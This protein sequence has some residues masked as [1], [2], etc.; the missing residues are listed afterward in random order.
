MSIKMVNYILIPVLVAL[1]IG[2]TIF[3]DYRSNTENS[4]LWMNKMEE[5]FAKN[6]EKTFEDV[7]KKLQLASDYVLSKQEILEAFANKD[8]DMLIQYVMPIHEN[9]SKNYET[10]LIHFHTPDLKSFLR[11]NDLNKYGDSLDYRNDIKVVLQKKEPIFVSSPGKSGVG[12]RYVRPVYYN[13]EFVGTMEVGFLLSKETLKQMGEAIVYQFLDEYGKPAEIITKPDEVEDFLQKYNIENLKAGKESSFRDD[14]YFYINYP[15]KNVDGQTFATILQ[16][17]DA[18]NIFSMQKKGITSQIIVGLLVALITIAVVI[19]FSS[20]T[21]K[22]ISTLVIEIEKLQKERNLAKGISFKSGKDEISSV[23]Q[24]LS[25]LLANLR[26]IIKEFV[27]SS[28]DSNIRLGTLISKIDDSYFSLKAFKESFE[29]GV[30]MAQT[31]SSS[32]EETTATIE[33]ISATTSNISK[34][35]QSVATAVEKITNDVQLSNDSIVQMK[36]SVDET[37]QGSQEIVGFANQL[38]EKSERIGDILKTITDIAEQTNLLALNAAIEAARAGEAGRGFAV[39]ADEIRKLAESTRI[40]ATEIG[41]ILTELRDGVG[42]IS[43]RLESFD[44]KIRNIEYATKLVSQKLEDIQSEVT[45]LEKE[46]S[47]LAAV[48][49]EQSASIEEIT[50]AMA[51]L[52]KTAT[53][54]SEQM[55]MNK[56]GAEEMENSFKL[57]K[58]SSFEVSESFKKIASIISSEIT[59]FSESELK[60]LINSAIEAHEKWVKDV[61][62]A[63]NRMDEKL[64]VVLDGSFCE[65]G[66]IYH[67]VRPP[68]KVADKWRELDA[69][70]KKIHALGKEIDEALRKKDYEKAKRL[71]KEVE[72]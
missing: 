68:E 28:K 67:F 58:Q 6:L 18:R 12:F 23:F 51:T 54:M 20:L 14:K 19:F 64:N 44:E 48:T 71:F 70:H 26:N 45:T 27:L 30:Q 62:S 65:F 31:V 66:S 39:V 1:G 57:M 9:L 4:G 37:I 55:E 38:K 7:Q 2:L 21:V 72:N 11:T 16:R 29:Y 53:E 50:A 32:V 56:E 60:D 15:L 17:I 46:A 63:I 24:K 40:S 41:K 3:L 59:I 34:A 42:G 22:K 49:E 25:E 8:R 5:T 33:E 61:E 43:E 13:N 47:N 52:S 36:G 10:N 35:A 69:P